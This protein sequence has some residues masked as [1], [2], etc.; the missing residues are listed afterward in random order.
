LAIAAH[1]AE[2]GL[3][4]KSAVLTWTNSYQAVQQLDAT[5]AELWQRWL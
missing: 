2:V 5:A 4:I 3:R 1:K